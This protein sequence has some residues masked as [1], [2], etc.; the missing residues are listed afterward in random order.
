MSNYT[1]VSLRKYADELF[2]IHPMFPSSMTGVG[3]DVHIGY[4]LKISN[5]RITAKGRVNHHDAALQLERELVLEPQSSM[6]CFSYEYI[7][8]SN[9]VAGSVHP[10]STLANQGIVQNSTT[11][12]P[13]WFGQHVYYLTNISTHDVVVNLLD[14]ICTISLRDV[15]DRSHAVPRDQRNVLIKYL[16]LYQGDTEGAFQYLMEESPLRKAF[17]FKVERV[18]RITRGGDASLYL[19]RS[20]SRLGRRK[21]TIATFLVAVVVFALSALVF[22]NVH[23]IVSNNSAVVQLAATIVGLIAGLLAIFEF[24]RGAR[25]G[26]RSSSDEG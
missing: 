3:Y 9:R 15:K 19:K 16:N 14:H 22:V 2:V 7:Y 24:V 23:S 10:R 18:K 4:Y 8:M 20:V 26:L 17:E 6:F 11:V 13:G 1:E 25:K 5:G 12:D 21:G